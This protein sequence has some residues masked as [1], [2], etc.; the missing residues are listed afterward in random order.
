MF[1][2][3]ISTRNKFQLREQKHEPIT[4]ICMYIIFLLI[5]CTILLYQNIKTS[6]EIKIVFYF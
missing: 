5:C 3:F 2:H 6:N 1:D 4:P